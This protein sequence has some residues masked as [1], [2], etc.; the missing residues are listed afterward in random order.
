MLENKETYIPFC[1][2]MYMLLP[3]YPNIKALYTIWY[4]QIFEKLFYVIRIFF[5]PGFWLF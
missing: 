2:R 1:E 5:L 3:H 4:L